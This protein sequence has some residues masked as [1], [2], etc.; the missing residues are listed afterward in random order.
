MNS[1]RIGRRQWPPTI[2]SPDLFN[3]EDRN[4]SRHLSEVALRSHWCAANF[5]IAIIEPGAD[6]KSSLP[7]LCLFSLIVGLLSLLV[8]IVVGGGD[9]EKLLP[10]AVL[11]GS[12]L[13]AMAL[14][15]DA[16]SP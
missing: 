5:A 14:R 16:P 15:R 4:Q 8:G 1:D 12:S 7:I 3:P 10:A 2:E 11:V 6:M 13:T 9:R